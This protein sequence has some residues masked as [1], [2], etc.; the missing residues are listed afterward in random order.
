MATYCKYYRTA[1]PADTGKAAVLNSYVSGPVRLTSTF[2]P[3]TSPCIVVL[4]LGLML[5]VVVDT[6]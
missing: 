2:M 4:T 5:G 3:T 6:N 1:S